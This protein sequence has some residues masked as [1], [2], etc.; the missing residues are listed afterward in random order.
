MKLIDG[1]AEFSCTAC[2]MSGTVLEHNMVV[3]DAATRRFA[4]CSRCG[5]GRVYVAGNRDRV[6]LCP[7]CHANDTTS[8]DL[9]VT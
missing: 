3:A 5:G 8:H 2:F 7:N 1:I 9:Y 6:I 4:P